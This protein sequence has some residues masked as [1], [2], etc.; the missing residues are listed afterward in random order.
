MVNRA[1]DSKY[2]P[3]FA[4]NWWKQTQKYNT[5]LTKPIIRR[6][7]EHKVKE[8]ETKKQTLQQDLNQN[9]QE[10]KDWEERFNELEELNSQQAQGYKIR[11]KELKETNQLYQQ[12]VNDLETQLFTLAKQK[13]KGK[14]ETQELLNQLENNWKEDKERWEQE[15]SQLQKANERFNQSLLNKGKKLNEA[16]QK[17]EQLEQ[18]KKELQ[19]QI[20]INQQ[21]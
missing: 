15:K 20:T 2:D 7:L 3:D 5:I 19:K 9:Q 8:L 21:D 13:I 10:N 11:E 16:Q 17:N 4:R 6:K 12:K 1:I 14:K 18:E